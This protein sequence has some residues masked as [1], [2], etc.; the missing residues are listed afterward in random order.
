M[1]AAQFVHT[2]HL[3]EE[4]VGVFHASPPLLSVGRAAL[5]LERCSVWVCCCP[6]WGRAPAAAAGHVPYDPV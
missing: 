2:G 1:V 5:P 3:E 6:G 4:A